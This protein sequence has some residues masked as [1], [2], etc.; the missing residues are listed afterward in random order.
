MVDKAVWPRGIGKPGT[1]KPG[2]HE[3]ECGKFFDVGI[4]FEI[5]PGVVY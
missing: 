1:I 2:I 4:K 5:K 3:I